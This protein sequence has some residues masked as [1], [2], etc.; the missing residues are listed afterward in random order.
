MQLRKDMYDL[1]MVPLPR[2]L[3]LSAHDEALNQR[4]KIVAVSPGEEL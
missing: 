4:A 2:S 1:E 3:S